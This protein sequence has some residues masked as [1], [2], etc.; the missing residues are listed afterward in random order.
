MQSQVRYRWELPGN[1]P[2][3][4]MEIVISN[5]VDRIWRVVVAPN[6]CITY[7]IMSKY[8]PR[9]TIYIHIQS[10]INIMKDNNWVITTKMVR[11]NYHYF[12]VVE[13]R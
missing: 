11:I 10:L 5:Y 2:V 13:N 8:Y 1:Y 12:V 7:T 3:F 9:E 4:T 6:V